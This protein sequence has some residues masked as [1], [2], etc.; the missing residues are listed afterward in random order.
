MGH[1]DISTTTI[2]TYLVETEPDEI[3]L[4]LAMSR[5]KTAS[6]L[7][8]R[9]SIEETILKDEKISKVEQKNKNIYRSMF[10]NVSA[11][12]LSDGKWKSALGAGKNRGFAGKN[13][14]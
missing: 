4:V 12:K 1:A 7:T 3:R 9:E 13:K 8:E 11:V 6:R 14:N 5:G 2:Y 10:L